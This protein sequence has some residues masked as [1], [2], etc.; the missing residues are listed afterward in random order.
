MANPTGYRNPAHWNLHGPR[1]VTVGFYDT[2][3]AARTAHEQALAEGRKPRTTP[4]VNHKRPD[5]TKVYSYKVEANEPNQEKR[6]V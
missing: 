1:R 2:R 4:V 6:H 3:E 5:G